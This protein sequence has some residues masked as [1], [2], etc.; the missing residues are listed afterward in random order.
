[1]GTF[2][3]TE[4]ISR[5]EWDFTKP[6]EK[7]GFVLHDKNGKPFPAEIGVGTLPEP[8]PE[9]TAEYLDVFRRI[10]E[11]GLAHGTKV[12]DRLGVADSSGVESDETFGTS[13]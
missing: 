10:L 6:D 3:A 7:T 8:T 1:M 5:I 12:R 2:T 13:N 9:A 4:R 11:K